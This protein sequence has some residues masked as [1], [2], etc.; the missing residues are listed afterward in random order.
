MF[1]CGEIVPARAPREQ[2]FAVYDPEKHSPT[3]SPT[4]RA[5]QDP[6]VACEIH[7]AWALWLLGYPDQASQKLDDALTL[8]QGSFT[9][10]ASRM[11]FTLL[12]DSINAGAKGEPPRSEKPQHSPSQENTDLRCL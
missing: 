12:P 6:G 8:A 7:A 5:G 1:Y 4:F 3:R 10:L 11:F 2:G 9:R